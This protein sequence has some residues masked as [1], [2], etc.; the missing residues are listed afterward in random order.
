MARTIAILTPE[1]AFGP[2]SNFAA[3]TVVNARPVLAFDASTDETSYWTIVAPQDITT[4]L[5]LVVSYMMAS[6]TSGNVVLDARVEA[7][8]DGDT[9]DLDNATFF[10]SANLSATTAVPGTAGYL[11]QISITLTNNDSI[12]AGDYVR[13]SLMRDVAPNDTATGDLYV[14]VAEL[15]DDGA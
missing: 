10:D 15:R 3:L 6:A 5:T 11:D 1:S 4:P 7:V 9:S 2:D 13:I 8:S 14:L 12:A